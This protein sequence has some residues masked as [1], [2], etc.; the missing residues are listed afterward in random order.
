MTVYDSILD[1]LSPFEI[2]R[3]Q[4]ASKQEY[5]NALADSVEMFGLLI[6]KSDLEYALATVEL[7]V[8]EASV[9]YN[10]LQVKYAELK[11]YLQY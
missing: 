10:T 3:D 5:V 9:D 2:K 7:A 4:Y 6:D 11:M 8:S 1:V